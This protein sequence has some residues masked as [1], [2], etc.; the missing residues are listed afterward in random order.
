MVTTMCYNPGEHIAPY[1]GK[2]GTGRVP[3]SWSIRDEMVG[4]GQAVP[5]L[6]GSE[7]EQVWIILGE[8]E[9]VEGA[10]RKRF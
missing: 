2:G 3:T 5:A 8:T 1:T 4:K 7:E 6:R 10:E 9:E